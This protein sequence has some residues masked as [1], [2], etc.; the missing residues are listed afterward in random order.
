MAKPFRR[1]VYLFMTRRREDVGQVLVFAHGSDRILAGIQTPGGT[2]EPGES[3]SEAALREAVEETGF[4]EFGP[5]RLLAEDRYESADET[6]ERH[7]FQLP[8]L[9]RTP[10][11]W[12]HRVQ[13]G[14]VD[15]GIDFDLRWA[16]L[17]GAGDLDDHFRAYLD[18]VRI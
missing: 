12:T 5:P 17:P 2:V 15:G 6:L 3:P 16:D 10:D 14:G 11:A 18:R 13:G 9:Q 8:V 1:R 4:T 7:F